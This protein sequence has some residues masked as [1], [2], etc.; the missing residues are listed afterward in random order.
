MP[1]KQFHASNG[2]VSC[3][4]TKLDIPAELAYI[5]SKLPGELE[6]F[7]MKDQQPH[8]IRMRVDSLWCELVSDWTAP[9]AEHHVTNTSGSVQPIDSHVTLPNDVNDFV[10][11]KY[12]DVFFAKVSQRTVRGNDV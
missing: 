7:L 9:H 6:K 4:V 5:F 8:L 3:D 2:G 11:T 1:R 12:V 10:F